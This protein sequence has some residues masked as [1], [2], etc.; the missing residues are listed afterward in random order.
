MDNKILLNES[1]DT[2]LQN[3]DLYESSLYDFHKTKLSLLLSGK[4]M[5]SYLDERISRPGDPEIRIK[6]IVTPN[7]EP[8]PG[9]NLSNLYDELINGN[10]G[11]RSFDELVQNFS[12]KF[13]PWHYITHKTMSFKG[14][15]DN[16][17]LGLPLIL[18]EKES[19]DRKIIVTSLPANLERKIPLN[20]F[21]EIL[22]T[23]D[24]QK[25]ASTKISDIAN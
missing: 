13:M 21:E 18:A 17:D 7:D 14:I 11:Y 1:V 22:S 25:S 20:R 16:F 9:S 8:F 23:P 12:K 15:R 19:D 3:A 24:Y 2:F 4:K 6:S 5:I 10:D